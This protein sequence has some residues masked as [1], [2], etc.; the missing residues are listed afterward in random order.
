MSVDDHRLTVRLGELAQAHAERAAA[1]AGVPAVRLDRLA[2]EPLHLDED[3]CREVADR[4]DAAPMVTAGA[5]R[6]Y[7]RLA[8]ENLRQFRLIGEAGIRVLPWTGPGQPY[9]DSRDLVARVRATGLLHVFL[10]RHGHGPAGADGDHPLR[11]PA[12][13]RAGGEELLHNDIFRA[14]H[15]VFGHVLFG[16]TFGPRGEF[17]ATRCHLA[18][19]PADLHPLV[20]AELVGQL[21]WFFHGPHLRRPDGT[22]P[23]RGEPGYVPPPRRPYPP[24][25][26]LVYDRRTLDRFAAL[27]TSPG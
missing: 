17:R 6:G 1:R 4:Y 20:F 9:R 19:Y 2:A 21:C 18:M 15:D 16:N 8:A 10:T 13:V 23:R 24:Q 27:F 14:V 22:L 11:A 25:K 3:F 7:A 5:A 12:G 26:Q